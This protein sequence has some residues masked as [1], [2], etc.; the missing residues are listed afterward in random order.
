MPDESLGVERATW[1]LDPERRVTGH[2]TGQQHQDGVRGNGEWD[3]GASEHSAR[4]GAKIRT[5]CQTRCKDHHRHGAELT[6]C[7][8]RA[9]VETGREQACESMMHMPNTRFGRNSCGATTKNFHA[10]SQPIVDQH[11]TRAMGNDNI[12]LCAAPAT[13]VAWSGG[14]IRRR[15]H[16]VM[17]KSIWGQP[18]CTRSE[19]DQERNMGAKH[20]HYQRSPWQINQRCNSS[21]LSPELQELA[22][23]QHLP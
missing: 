22:S 9:H 3:L 18:N 5:L 11:R 19:S 23:R 12:R 8:E 20:W 17:R 2:T 21:T 15:P 1:D 4:P 6:N 14:L 10:T 7:A 13:W 16:D